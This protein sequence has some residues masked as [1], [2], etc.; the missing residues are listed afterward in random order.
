M[1]YQIVA[2][3]SRPASKKKSARTL[4]SRPWDEAA[5]IVVGRFFGRAGLIG[6]LAC[7]LGSRLGP[8]VECLL[9]PRGLFDLDAGEVNS[10]WLL[11]EGSKGIESRR[12]SSSSDRGSSDAGGNIGKSVAFRY[13]LPRGLSKVCICT[14]LSKTLATS[15]EGYWTNHCCKFHEY[16][17]T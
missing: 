5:P 13:S 17:G 11:C 16:F 7:R 9:R 1:I 15:V 2:S 14:T 3:S 8:I 12:G 10:G 6:R 4:N